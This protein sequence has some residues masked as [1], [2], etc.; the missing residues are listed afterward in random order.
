[1]KSELIQ[2]G[3]DWDQSEETK[4]TQNS[5]KNEKNKKIV[6]KM[7]LLNPLFYLNSKVNQAIYFVSFERDL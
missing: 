6:M 7:Q 1:M 4:M 5:A 2:W 3:G